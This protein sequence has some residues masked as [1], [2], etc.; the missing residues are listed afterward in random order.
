VNVPRRNGFTA[1]VA[2]GGQ[3]V[4]INDAVHHPLYAT[5][6]AQK[7]GVQ[8]IAGFPLKRAGRVLGVFTIAFLTPHIFDEEEL[9]VLGLLADQAAVAIENARLYE[10]ARQDA[11]T[12]SMLLREV[13]HRVKNN[14]T[15][16]VGL[17]RAEQSHA[18]VEDQPIYQPI[19]QNLINRVQG[20][21]TVHSL[22]SASEWSP[23]SL[24]ELTAQ[25][26][27][28]TMQTL[29]R[30]KRLSVDVTPSLVRVTPDQ[31]H[32]LALVINELTTNTIKHGLQERETARIGVRIEPDEDTVQFEF[33]DDGPGYPDEVLQ[34]EHSGVGFDLIWNLVRK[35]LGGELSLH[36]DRGAVAVIRFAAQ[37]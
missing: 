27:R 5:L 15:A 33:R 19:M 1:I 18:R 24:S 11:E 37:A 29:P 28:S 17:L 8:T 3:A 22:L 4:V 9:R 12:K 2:Q 10:Q 21:A 13:N 20:L 26:I 31:A 25:V 36:N 16:I 6:E 32:S 23:L 30:D 7:W 35:N 34:L 14:L